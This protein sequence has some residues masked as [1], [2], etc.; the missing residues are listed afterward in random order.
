MKFCV[1]KT[2]FK[3]RI[4]HKLKITWEEHQKN[5]S[6]FYANKFNI[7]REKKQQMYVFCI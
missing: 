4:L 6:Q 3:A 5:K 1:I 2:C 7:K